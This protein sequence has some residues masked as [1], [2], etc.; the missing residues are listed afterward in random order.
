MICAEVKKTY[1]LKIVNYY[2]YSTSTEDIL[3]V[4]FA[5]FEKANGTA[6]ET[7]ST[8]L[9][10]ISIKCYCSIYDVL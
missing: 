2:C 7:T 6:G 10:D 4:Y 5:S 9:F 1:N 8:F 3:H